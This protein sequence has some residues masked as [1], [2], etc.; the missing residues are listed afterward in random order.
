MNQPPTIP[1]DRTAPPG[2]PRVPTTPSDS[3]LRSTLLSGSLA[4]VAAALLNL[5]LH[6]PLDPYFN[7]ATVVLGVLAAAVAAGVLWARIRSRPRGLV[8]FRATVGIATVV[9][10]AVSVLAELVISGAVAYFAPLAALALGLIALLVPSA[11]VARLAG[12]LPLT[13]ACVLASLAIGAGLAT[14]R[15]TRVVALTLPPVAASNPSLPTP[16]AA[17]TTP[18]ASAPTATAVTPATVA[19]APTAIAVSTGPVATAIPPASTA[20]APTGAPASQLASPATPTPTAAV[21]QP[22]PTVPA[23]SAQQSSTARTAGTYD[24]VQFVVGT[25]SKATFT[26]REKLVQ[27]PL[28][29]DA[30]LTTG[31]LTGD[32]FLDGRPSTIRINLHSLTSDQNF[33]DLYVR[34]QMFP[35]QPTATLTV[36]GIGGVPEGLASGREVTLTVAG[37][38]NIKARDFPIEFDIVA[39]D[40]GGVIYILGKTRFT[41][42][43]LGLSVPRARSVTSVDNDVRVEVLLA[44]R[45]A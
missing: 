22:S 15:D 18:F 21:A 31:G 7:S 16:V 35:D 44:I 20:P 41:W 1:P 33:R 17:A 28:P 11:L 29:N 3:A 23:T 30:V 14:Q 5:P 13:A 25:G 4:A 6:S 39:R 27:L 42:A 37:M 45:P 8:A 12:S 10:V 2:S 9:A 40:D 34:T 24:G 26:V 19:A 36:P 43:D 32:V 38:L